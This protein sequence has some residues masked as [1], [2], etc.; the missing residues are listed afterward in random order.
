MSDTS[1]YKS[2]VGKLSG[3][4]E[5]IFHFVTDIR[6][7][8]RFAPKGA[9]IDWEAKKESGNFGV[10]SLGKVNFR[11][12]EKEQFSKVTYSGDVLKE[13]TFR[14]ALRIGRDS[15]NFAEVTLDLQAEMNPILKMMASKPIA[16]FLETLINEMEEFRGWKVINE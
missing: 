16:Q 3:S 6:N 15:N 7:F 2:R 5:E 9:I 14:M 11:I 8:Q 13:N 1:D 12:C 10:P 4:P